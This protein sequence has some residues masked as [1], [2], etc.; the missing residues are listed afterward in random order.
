MRREGIKRVVEKIQFFADC[1][2]ELTDTLVGLLKP[3]SFGK[4]SL[5]SIVKLIYLDEY[6]FHKGDAG[7]EMYFISQ[8][9][10]QVVSEDG[11]TIF[12][13]LHEGDFFGEIAL[14]TSQVRLSWN[15]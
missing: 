5:S 9:L 12:K 13:I 6:I 15:L 1:P 7:N 11:K 8:G 3:Q 14:L 10:V 2:K 4:G